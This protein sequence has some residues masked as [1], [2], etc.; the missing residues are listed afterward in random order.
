LR[1]KGEFVDEFVD[2][3]TQRSILRLLT[4]QPAISAKRIAEQVGMSPRGVQKSIDA[5]KRRGLCAG[6]F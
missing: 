6:S 4:A 2:N 3:E 5:M 1:D